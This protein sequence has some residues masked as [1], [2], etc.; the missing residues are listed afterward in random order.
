MLHNSLT[1][2]S[3]PVTAIQAVSIVPSLQ[4]VPRIVTPTSIDTGTRPLST[5]SII[6]I[7]GVVVTVLI[8]IGTLIVTVLGIALA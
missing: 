2:T 4:T 5:E 7:I 3:K 1:T 6:S 8:G